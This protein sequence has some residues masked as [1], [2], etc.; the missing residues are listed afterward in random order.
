MRNFLMAATA[1]AGVA[2]AMTGTAQA[3]MPNQPI[4]SDSL[5]LNGNGGDFPAPGTVTVRIRARVVV[6]GGYGTDSGT[7]GK[8]GVTNAAGTGQAGNGYKNQGQFFGSSMRIYPGAD[9][10]AANG[11]KYGGAI[12]LRQGGG[13]GY[14]SSG[15]NTVFVRRSYLYF[16]GNWGK[17][18]I[19]ANDGALGQLINVGALEAFDWTGGLNGS[20]QF[21]NCGA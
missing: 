20:E 11:L 13:G 10:V 2:V 4:V 18:I 9:G 5:G 21:L 7:V 19:G 17:T 14:G 16:A 12:E 8:A 1:I 3:Q 15:S 6:E